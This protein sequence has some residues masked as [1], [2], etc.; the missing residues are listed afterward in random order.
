M[1]LNTCHLSDVNIAWEFLSVM[2]SEYV[3]DTIGLLVNESTAWIKSDCSKNHL[4][5]R[6]FSEINLTIFMMYLWCFGMKPC[7]LQNSIII[8]IWGLV[9]L[10]VAFKGSDGF[11]SQSCKEYFHI[12]T[13]FAIVSIFV[14]FPPMGK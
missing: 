8:S 5:S 9:W 7:Q 12:W 4:T 11:I 14:F 1:F 13:F 3:T 10:C 6:G 2:T